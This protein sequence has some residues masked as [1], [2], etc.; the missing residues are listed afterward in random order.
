MQGAYRPGAVVGERQL[1]DRLDE[2]NELDQHY[3][4]WIAEY[5]RPR[6]PDLVTAFQEAL[7]AYER[8]KSLGR[9]D[10]EDAER[11]LAHA[12]SPRTPL[13]ENAA[14]MLGKLYA[15]QP[16]L[17]PFVRRL[18][19][20]TRVHERVNALV[21]L[22]SCPPTQL[23]LDVFERLLRDRSS[24]VRTLSADRIVQ[25]DSQQ[26]V[27]ALAAAVDRVSDVVIAAE[28][29]AS[30]DYL[31]LG[32]NVQSRGKDGVRVSC[33]RP[34]GGVVSRRFTHEEY[35]EMGQAWIAG[36]LERVQVCA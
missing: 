25:H 33:L 26:L 27:D 5:L 6:H 17:A 20:G 29:Q 9:I 36:Q 12:S 21:A 28:L 7:E 13:G 18:A 31:R 23:H 10:E 34:G 16:E 24:R 22:A 15:H 32:F 8:G 19:E 2:M 14:A 30:L 3:T 35:A 4:K 1:S 11:L